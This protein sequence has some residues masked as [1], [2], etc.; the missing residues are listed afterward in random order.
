[1]GMRADDFAKA[2]LD[3]MMTQSGRSAAYLLLGWGT[4]LHL[5]LCLRGSVYVPEDDVMINPTEFMGVPIVVDE[6]REFA[7]TALPD[8]DDV[9]FHPTHPGA[10]ED[11]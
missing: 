11:E 2:A 7:A 6:T 3:R 10:T 5:G 8:L 9:R 1:M 4:W